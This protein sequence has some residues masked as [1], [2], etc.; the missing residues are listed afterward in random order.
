MPDIE[1]ALDVNL[2]QTQRRDSQLERALDYI[3]SKQ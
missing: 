1:Q 3:H 2:W